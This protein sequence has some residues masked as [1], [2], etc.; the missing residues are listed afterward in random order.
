MG[1]YPFEYET[2]HILMS[3]GARYKSKKTKIINEA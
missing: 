3:F 1:I 2:L